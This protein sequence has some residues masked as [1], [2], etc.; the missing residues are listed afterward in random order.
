MMQEIEQQIEMMDA[1]FMKSI[2]SCGHKCIPPTYKD[3]ELN[4][5]ESVCVQRCMNKFF[6]SLEVVSAQLAEIGMQPK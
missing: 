6:K 4:K 1:V 2:G 5:G 3:G